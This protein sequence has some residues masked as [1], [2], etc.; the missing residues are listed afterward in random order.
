[1]V[2][3]DSAGTGRRERHK[4]AMWERLYTAAIELFTEHGY[5]ETSIDDIAERADVARGTFFNYF[6]RKEDVIA[7][8]GERRRAALRIGL[9]EE[10]ATGDRNVAACLES[11]MRTL[12]RINREEWRTARVMLPAWVRA[13]H[14]IYEKPYLAEQF[15]ELIV[16]GQRA[17]DLSPDTDPMLAGNL[18]RELYLGTLYRYI[19]ADADPASLEEELVAVTRIVL[20]GLVRADSLIRSTG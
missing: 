1:M 19:G 11:N 16:T 3:P 2:E 14:P 4:R 8:W 12:A 10:S 15:A 5:D 9:S 6:D 18:L 13:G 7:A 17:G 20:L